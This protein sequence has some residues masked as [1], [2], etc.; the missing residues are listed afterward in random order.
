MATPKVMPGRKTLVGVV[1][2]ATAAIVAPFV[3]GWESGG[4]P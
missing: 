2:L 4:K 1:G 3:S